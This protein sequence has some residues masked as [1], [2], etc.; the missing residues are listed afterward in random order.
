MVVPFLHGRDSGQP[1]SLTSAV[2]N[3]RYLRG[4][5]GEILCRRLDVGARRNQGWGLRL[6]TSGLFIPTGLKKSGKVGGYTERKEKHGT[7]P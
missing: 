2:L 3:R 1:K 5:Q 4:V 7:K 6:G